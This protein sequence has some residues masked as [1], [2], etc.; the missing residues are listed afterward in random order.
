ML[1]PASGSI[2]ADLTSGKMSDDGETLGEYKSLAHDDENAALFKF[3]EPLSITRQHIDCAKIPQTALWKL[4]QQEFSCLSGMKWSSLDHAIEKNLQWPLLS[5]T[6]VGL[7][8]QQKCDY[9]VRPHERSVLLK[10]TWGLIK[11][12]RT[13]N[14]SGSDAKKEYWRAISDH[15][16]WKNGDWGMADFATTGEYFNP[17]ASEAITGTMDRTTVNLS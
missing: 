5:P 8:T 12:Y 3:L 11:A 9:R 15:R 10:T 6:D 13:E 2:Q 7:E 17:C 1:L 16:F 14:S 4:Y